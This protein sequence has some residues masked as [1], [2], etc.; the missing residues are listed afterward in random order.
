MVSLKTRHI[1]SKLVRMGVPRMGSSQEEND[2]EGT[3][4]RH[5]FHPVEFIF[6]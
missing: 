4:W 6:N 5:D 1:S 2:W 3:Q